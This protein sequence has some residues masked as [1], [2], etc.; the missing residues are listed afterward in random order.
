MDLES[1]HHMQAHIHI[2]R[3]GKDL[4]RSSYI[5]WVQKCGWGR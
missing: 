3:L 2:E 1:G 5:S 4:S